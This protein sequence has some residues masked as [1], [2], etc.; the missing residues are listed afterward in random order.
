MNEKKEFYIWFIRETKALIPKWVYDKITPIYHFF[1]A[2]L[3]AVVY[4]NPSKN[5]FVIGVTGTKGKT[6]TVELINNILKTSGKK[7]AI[8]SSLRMQVADNPE[9]PNKMTMPGRMILQKFFRDAVKAGCEYVVFEMTSEGA[10]QFRHKFIYLD[11]F[12]FTNI[13]PEHIESHGSYEKYLAAKVSLGESLNKGIKKETYVFVNTDAND[14]DSFIELKATHKI[15]Y[16]ISDAE[17]FEIQ[18]SLEV[19]TFKGVQ[20]STRLKGKFNIYNALA[21]ATCTHEL[22]IPIEEIKKGIEG[23]EYIPGRMQRIIVND[24]HG[25]PYKDFDVYVDYA[26]TPDSLKKACGALSGTP[27]IC[28]LGSAGGGRDKWKRPI[29]GKISVDYCKKIIL[30]TDDP[31]DEDVSDINKDILRGVDIANKD[32]TKN[33]K[34]PIPSEEIEDRKEAI[35]TA[36]REAKKG[37]AV[38]ITGK[39]AD[40]YYWGPRGKRIP[41][42]DI[43]ETK[44]LLE[45]HINR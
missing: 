16:S 39:G 37:D 17:P 45:R 14:S 26:H 18:P 41:W 19:F 2:F 22:G 4:R 43:V 3:G 15:P 33:G 24:R 40:T 9:I 32:R 10:K 1:W 8:I 12:V 25:K 38:L 20:I 35:R 42:S 29:I 11:A 34:E 27:I 30:T 5:I 21:A 36:I 13:Y 28:I 23:V 7:T 31:Y 44:K 6:S